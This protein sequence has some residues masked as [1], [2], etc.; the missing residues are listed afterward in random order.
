LALGCGCVY[1]YVNALNKH[2][3]EEIAQHAKDLEFYAKQTAAIEVRA[4]PSS[5]PLVRVGPQSQGFAGRH[6]GERKHAWIAQATWPHSSHEAYT[7][8]YIRWMQRQDELAETKEGIASKTKQATQ[9]LRHAHPRTSRAYTSN[10]TRELMRT[11]THAHPRAPDARNHARTDARA[12]NRHA[13]THDMRAGAHKH[14]LPPR[15]FF[16]LRVRVCV[17]ACV[18]V[19]VCACACVRACACVHAHAAVGRG[20]AAGTHGDRRTARQSRRAPGQGQRFDP[21]CTHAM[22]RARISTHARAHTA[23]VG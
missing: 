3:Q 4:S 10:R 16:R 13:R 22:V 9:A 18:C 6:A 19:R 12:R 5:A 14:G 1:F 7:M 23:A 21:N 15:A 17:R 2:A 11:H 20:D 8:P